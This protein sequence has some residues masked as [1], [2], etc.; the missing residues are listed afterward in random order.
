MTSREER[1]VHR[2]GREIH[3]TPIE[4]LRVLLRH[5]GRSLTHRALLQQVWGPA[6]STDR[7]I[8]RTHIGN[9]RRKL[10]G[11]DGPSLIGT[12]HGI[13]YR[14]TD[15]R[16]E[17]LRRPRHASPDTGAFAFIARDAPR[18]T[19]PSDSAGSTSYHGHRRSSVAR[20][21]RCR[22]PDARKEIS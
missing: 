2:D 20:R 10:E 5:R 14:L 1:A 8:L 4:L 11:S 16:S 15:L 9:L 19:R 22:A 17:N 3:L 12:H 6:Y 18:Q 21:D 13:G 7:S